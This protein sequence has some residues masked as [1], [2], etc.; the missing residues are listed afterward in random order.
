VARMYGEIKRRPV[1]VVAE[2]QGVLPL[3][4]QVRSEESGRTPTVSEGPRVA[5]N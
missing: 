2:R 1:Y 4:Q 3:A 5:S